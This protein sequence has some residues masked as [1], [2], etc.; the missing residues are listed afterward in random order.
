[1]INEHSSIMAAVQKRK[2]RNVA[3]LNVLPPQKKGRVHSIRRPIRLVNRSCESSD[4]ESLDNHDNAASDDLSVVDLDSVDSSAESQHT[5]RKLKATEGWG[6]LRKSA[7]HAVVEGKSM[8][9]QTQCVHC[10]NAGAEIRCVQC[11][12]SVFL[13]QSC[14]IFIHKYS[15]SHT[16]ELWKVII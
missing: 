1:M 12:P 15:Y 5:Q 2:R 14:A 13:C 7:L 6:K 9:P 3:T 16:P 8:L 10:N 11:G 4:I